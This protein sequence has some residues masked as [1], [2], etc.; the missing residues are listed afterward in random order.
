MYMEMTA[1][2]LKNAYELD[3]SLLAEFSVHAP[4]MNVKTNE[5]GIFKVK[6][7]KDIDK[8]KAGIE[9]R[10]AFV[11]EQFKTYLQDQYEIAKD[12]RVVTNG[13]YVLFV[14]SEDADEIEKAFRDALDK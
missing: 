1:D 10:A 14:I 3:A 6:N 7:K 2:D 8:V 12:Y 4:M 11:Q 13:S 9:K 5:I